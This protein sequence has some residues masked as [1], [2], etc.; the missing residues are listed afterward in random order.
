MYGLVAEIVM[1]KKIILLF[2]G[3]ALSRSRAF[4]LLKTLSLLVSNFVRSLITRNWLSFEITSK[5]SYIVTHTKIDLP[6]PKFE[7]PA[8]EANKQFLRDRIDDLL[9]TAQ[10]AVLCAV[11][12][13]L[14]FFYY[15]DWLIN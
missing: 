7:Y 8:T 11:A 2:I 4:G 5:E 13:I 10:I 9:L 15:L 6:N 14:G 3:L 1:K 12:L